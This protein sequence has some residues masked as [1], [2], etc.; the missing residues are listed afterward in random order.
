ML[1]LIL[2]GMGERI[3]A[4]ETS[5]SKHIIPRCQYKKMAC[6]AIEVSL[7]PIAIVLFSHVV[8]GNNFYLICIM[9]P[10]LVQVRIH[11]TR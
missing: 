8:F 2:P 5:V 9:I 10:I 1:T 3:D 6:R 4:D 7:F 11:D